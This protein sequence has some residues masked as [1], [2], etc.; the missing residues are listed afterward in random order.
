MNESR[1]GAVLC[2]KNSTIDPMWGSSRCE[3]RV[4]RSPGGTQ[5]A[6]PGGRGF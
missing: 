5:E 4:P 2:Q 1:G 6:T 3:G